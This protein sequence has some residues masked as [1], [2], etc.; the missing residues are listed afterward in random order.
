MVK[1]LRISGFNPKS[2]GKIFEVFAEYGKLVGIL[3]SRNDNEGLVTFSHHKSLNYVLRN[4]KIIEREGE[5]SE[6]FIQFSY[7]L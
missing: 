7:L 5:L 1:R 3:L 4:R 6:T 2:G